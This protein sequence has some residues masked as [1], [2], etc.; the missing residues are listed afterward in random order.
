MDVIGNRLMIEDKKLIL[1]FK[2]IS[3]CYVLTYAGIPFLSSI[4]TIVIPFIM[5]FFL[6]QCYLII[7]KRELIHQVDCNIIIKIYLLWNIIILA[8]GYWDAADYWDYKTL[9]MG[10]TTALLLPVIMFLGCRFDIILRMFS[11][12]FKTFLVLSLILVNRIYY[13]VLGLSF[14]FAIPCIPFFK[15]RILTLGCILFFC[16]SINFDSRAWMI[17]LAFAIILLL[18]Y[19]FFRKFIWIKMIKVLFFIILLT[20]IVFVV[21]GRTTE[22]N[23]FK[24][25]NYISGKNI[26][27][28]DLADTRSHLY[29]LVQAKLEDEGKE[30]IGLGGTSEYWTGFYNDITTNNKG[31]NKKGR[32]H[33]ESGL[34]NMYL[35]GGW[36]NAILYSLLFIV[37]S[38]SAIFKSNSML[39]KLLGLFIIFRWVISF[40]D[41][42]EGWIVSNIMMFITMGTCLSTQFRKL[43]DNELI[44]IIK[45]I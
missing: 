16:L 36:I 25:D 21:L 44:K 9:I 42:P 28:E 14:L 3:I 23:V 7:R 1:I 34:L 17:R 35:Y 31:F 11:F 22:F 33:T 27:Q 6:G 20:P 8:R 2:I 13:V 12:L 15:K 18:V 45:Q 32:N 43:S 29:S 30:L 39:C 26:K 24:M 5:Y 38:Y 40:I 41:E 4:A 19:K 10:R 37:S